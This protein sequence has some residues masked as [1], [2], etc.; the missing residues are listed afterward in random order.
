MK[1]FIAHTK[2]RSGEEHC[3]RDHLIKVSDIICTFT[4]EPS[5]QQIFKVTGLLHDL[6]KYQP[7]FQRYLIQAGPR[8]SVPHA[9]WGAALARQVGQNEVAFVIDGHHKGL[10]DKADLKDSIDWIF[11]LV[12]E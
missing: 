9:S 11:A 6:G 3:L 10:P 2:N 4:D 5:F 7:A 8:G 12:C 1:S